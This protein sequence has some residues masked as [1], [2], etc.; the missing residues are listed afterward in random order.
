MLPDRVSN[1]GPLTYESGVLSTALRGLAK[2]VVLHSNFYL[3]KCLTPASVFYCPYIDSLS[4]YQLQFYRYSD[5]ISPIK[6]PRDSSTLEKWG[7][8]T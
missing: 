3:K 6:G 4:Q 1:P 8:V 5:C 7:A 2:L